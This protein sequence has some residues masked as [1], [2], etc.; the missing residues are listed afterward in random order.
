MERC[1]WVGE[2]TQKT[3]QQITESVQFAGKTFPVIEGTSPRATNTEERLIT[4][5]PSPQTSSHTRPSMTRQ[6]ICSTVIQ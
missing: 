4:A 6:Q 2:N 5:V 1:N 3:A